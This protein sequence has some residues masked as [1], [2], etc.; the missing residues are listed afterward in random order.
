TL[1]PEVGTG[2][3]DVLVPHFLRSQLLRPGFLRLSLWLGVARQMPSWA[4]LQFLNHGVTREDLDRVL[5][6]ITGLESWANTWE[7]LGREQVKAA[8]E[9]E[10]RGDRRSAGSY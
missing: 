7:E 4:K 1:M 5:G 2:R 9:A 8:Q 10:T 3:L 6:R